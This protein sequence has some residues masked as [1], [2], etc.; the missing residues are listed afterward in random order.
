MMGIMA[1]IG[2][3]GSIASG[4][5]TFCRL[6]ARKLDADIFDADVC[7]RELLENDGGVRARVLAEISAS[8]YGGDGRPDR[9]EIRRVVFND[10][11]AKA[12]LEA[13]LHPLVRRRWIEE[14][15]VCRERPLLM[16]IPLLFE[17]GAWDYPV[18]AVACSE[19]VQLQRLSARGLDAV[20]AGK[21]IRS[22][23]PIAEKIALSTHVVWNDGSLEALER[24]A[25][26]MAGIIRS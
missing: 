10:P 6:L 21:I 5:T 18:I 17:A 1:V 16:D 8:A 7:A 11:K 3:T 12:R 22:Q 2:I 23:L 24:Q 15:V 4:K 9:A 19:E 25:D 14:L 20:M 26:V 13:I